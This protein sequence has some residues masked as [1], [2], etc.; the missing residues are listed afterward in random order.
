MIQPDFRLRIEQYIRREASP[1]YKYSHQS[2][3]YALTQD[4]AT[5]STPPLRYDD[6]VVFAAAYLHDLGVFLGIARILQ[7]SSR[8]GTTWPMRPGKHPPC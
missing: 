2:R 8:L 7:P 1:A 3:L 6:D 4:I 5:G